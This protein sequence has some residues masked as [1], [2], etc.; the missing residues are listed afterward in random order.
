MILLILLIFLFQSSLCETN[1]KIIL[2]M[3]LTT[4]SKNVPVISNLEVVE[5]IKVN[6]EIVPTATKIPP[7]VGEEYEVT[8][9]FKIPLRNCSRL[10]LNVDTPI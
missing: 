5:S 6:N 7:V 8:I 1:N 3:P 2:Q 4:K 10:F 9:Y